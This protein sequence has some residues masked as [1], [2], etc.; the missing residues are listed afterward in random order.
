MRTRSGAGAPARG[1]SPREATKR[2]TS[3]P[4]GASEPCI[5]G[6]PSPTSGCKPV[7]NACGHGET[8]A[9]SRGAVFAG[10]AGES[11]PL[12]LA[13]RAVVDT[14]STANPNAGG[15]VMRLAISRGTVAVCECR[16]RLI[17]GR[18][19]A[20]GRSPFPGEASPARAAISLAGVSPAQ[21]FVESDALSATPSRPAN[22]WHRFVV[23]DK[24]SPAESIVSPEPASGSA[25]S[26]L[27][28]PLP[29]AS[30]VCA[31]SGKL[32][33]GSAVAE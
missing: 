5:D 24:A 15:E 18:R 9:A 26:V 17:V 30:E 33:G 21:G 7:G 10:M 12:S 8:G 25:A 11:D 27:N 32:S 6:A 29:F 20:D 3:V 4:A 14:A 22:P 2:K 1:G 28:P 16:V 23:P 19:P 13:S 31:S